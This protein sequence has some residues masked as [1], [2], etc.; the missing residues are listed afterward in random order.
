M[1]QIKF[2][3]EAGCGRG[4]SSVG[5]QEKLIGQSRGRGRPSELEP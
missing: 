2:W 5:V 4:Q 3:S 1:M